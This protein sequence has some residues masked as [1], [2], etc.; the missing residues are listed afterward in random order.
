MPTLHETIEFIKKAHEGQVTKA[1]EPY[2]THPVGVLNL[3]SE[4]AT[5]DEKHAALLHDVIED[6][7]TT[8]EDL[9]RA[10]YSERTIYLVLSLS[11]PDGENRPTYM[12]WIRQIA[13]T[14]DKGLIRIKLADNTHNSLPERIAALPESERDIISRYIRSAKILKEALDD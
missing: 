8:V 1:G 2:W 9:I 10:G 13:G 6:T 4:E 14:G 11:R 12:Q 3:L 7:T 5:E